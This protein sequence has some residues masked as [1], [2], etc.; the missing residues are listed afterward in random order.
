MRLE[1]LNEAT[2]LLGSHVLQLEEA[3]TPLRKLYFLMQGTLM[4]PATAPVLKPAIEESIG[5]LLRSIPSQETCYSL[6]RVLELLRRR[7]TFEAMKAVR[8][9]IAAEAGSSSPPQ[10]WPAR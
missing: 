8:E 5:E 10:G 9:L 6:V 2:F 3:T 1:L 4:D 7:A